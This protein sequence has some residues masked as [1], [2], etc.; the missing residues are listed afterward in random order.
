[1]D[2]DLDTAIAPLL[3]RLDEYER[4]GNAIR[5]AINVFCEEYGKPPMFPE[6]GGSAGGPK[7]TKIKDDT[8]YGKKQQT[9]IRE[10]LDMR[11]AQGLGPAK[12]REI[13]DALKQG[14]YQFETKDDEIALVS[15]R[16]LLRKRSNIFHKLP[17]GSYGL[18]SWYPDA[19]PAKDASEADTEDAEAQALALRMAA[20]APATE[21]PAVT[22]DSEPQPPPIRHRERLR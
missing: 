6:G 20:S 8:F 7:I 2:N 10:Y 11:K 14:G 1:M 18:D 4:K 13:F 16:A 12:P 17:T 22:P 5:M 3:R 21:R 9:A 19:K 15:L